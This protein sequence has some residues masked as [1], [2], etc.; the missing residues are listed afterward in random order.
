[1][2]AGV[3]SMRPQLTNTLGMASMI[4]SRD[5]WFDGRGVMPDEIINNIAKEYNL[6][7]W[8]MRFALYGD[9]AV[10][11][12]NFEVVKKRFGQ[13]PSAVLVGEKH[14]P[15]DWDTLANPHE[16]VMI[17]R[18]SLDLYKM[19]GWSGGDEGGHVDFAPVIP[20]TGKRAAAAHQT[21]TKMLAEVGMDFLGGMIPING[22]ATPFIN[23]ISFDTKNPEQVDNAYSVARKMVDTMGKMGYGEYRAH[24]SFMDLAAEQFAFNNHAQARFNESIKDTIDPNGII[25]PGKNGIWGTRM[26][27]EGFPKR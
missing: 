23:V 22:R 18:P 11:D 17:G 7:R 19:A 14:G 20:L 15:E 12:H 25:A 3:V 27:N 13:I 21:M 1:M 8:M 5:E 16:R 10:V 26:R 6:G 4:T 24:P 2:L 9:E